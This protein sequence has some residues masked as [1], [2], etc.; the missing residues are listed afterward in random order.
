MLVPTERFCQYEYES[1]GTHW[2]QLIAR[3]KLQTVLR[4]DSDRQDK[5]N[6]PPDLDLGGI[7]NV[8]TLLIIF[9][10]QRKNLP[11]TKSL[12]NFY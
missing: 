1:S 10:N 2:S 11:M 5:N 3:L 6:K 9:F 12:S 7:K 4:N 8:W